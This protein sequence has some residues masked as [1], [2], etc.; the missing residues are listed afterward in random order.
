MSGPQRKDLAWNYAISM[1]V[2]AKGANKGYKYLKCT[3]CSKE[4]SGGVKRVN[5][6][7]GCNHKNVAPCS[8]VPDDFKNSMKEYLR[9]FEESK[10][11]KQRE[12]DDAVD[13]GAYFGVDLPF[14]ANVER[15]IRGPMDRFIAN[16]LED[17]KVVPPSA[18]AKEHRS[19]VY[20]D[21]GRFLFENAIPFNCIRSPSFIS[22]VR[23][24][25][26]YGRGLKPPSMHEMRT[27][28][29]KEEVK[30]TSA[31]VDEIKATW[32]H[33]GKLF[34][35]L[36]EVVEEIG[37]EHVVQV[38]TDNGAAYKAAERLLMDKRTSLYWT[39]CAAHCIDLMLEKI[40]E[41]PQH[42]NA[43]LKAKRVTNYIHNHQWI[44]SLT[45]KFAKKDLLRP[46]ATQFA[47]AYLTLESMYELKQPLEQMFVSRDWIGCAWAKKDEGKAVRKIIMSDNSFWASV[48]YSIKTTK[49]LVDVLRVVDGERAPVM[50][51][52]YAAMDEAK[53]K[54]AKNLNDEVGA[55]KEI[56]NIIDDKWEKQLH[57]DLH[58]TAYY[59]NPQ[60]RWG[61]NVSEHAE[62]K[63]GLFNCMERMI[64]DNDTYLKVDVQLDEYKN[65]REL[66]GSRASMST[67]T[68]RAPVDW[69]EH[70]GD[71]VPHLKAQREFLGLLARPQ[72]VNRQLRKEKDDPLVV[73]DVASDDEWIANPNDENDI[74]VD[75]ANSDEIE[76]DHMDEGT[77]S[78]IP[79]K[80]GRSEV[81][82][83][84]KG[85]EVEHRLVDEDLD[86]DD[87]SAGDD[88]N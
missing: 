66:F 26:G 79:R 80:R 72:L 14:P 22:M 11:T 85:K 73:E 47:T 19:R 15:G 82:K 76:A 3:F 84:G 6:H 88:Y 8:R 42:K 46:A 50:G 35:L 62:I 2:L 56:W 20:L 32:K 55:Y 75:D 83:K 17:G 64:K 54:I 30:T 7:L 1:E 24:I 87:E 65:K 16:E 41:L 45:R 61:E 77:S 49:P 81:S 37:E 18:T 69:W 60:F 33:T 78:S 27:W 38:I 28:I 40:G 12:F 67:Y 43:L 44:L 53:E 71:E 13:G 68:S 52:I 86:E 63:K 25:G 39:P 34:E 9:T 36:D 70:F 21:I 48:V 23:S 59:L 10:H 5:D 58:A 51:F 57:R 31:I 29:L 4:I 74:D